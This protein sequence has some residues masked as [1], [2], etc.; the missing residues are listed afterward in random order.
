MMP[1]SWRATFADWAKTPEHGA[2]VAESRHRIG[3]AL[4]SCQQPYVA[5]SAG[6]DSGV[7]MH[8]ILQQHPP[9]VV[10]HSDYGREKV[11]EPVWREINAMVSR[12]GIRDFRSHVHDPQPK[13]SLYRLAAEGFDLVFVGLR[14][15]ESAGRRERMKSGRAFG[16]IRECW[17]IERWTWMDVWAYTVA[18]DVPY[19]S[20]Y[21]DRAAIA[22]YDKARFKTLFDPAFHHFG[23][24]S[25]DGIAH[26]RL[27]GQ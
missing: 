23:S 16:P 2:A 6:K 9:I 14:A 12:F 26:W 11:P 18:N 27:R 22:G 5:W 13:A 19:L 15:E 10:V 21:D 24:E 1:A 7:M 4:A 25:L 3:A 8:L 17:P 20:L